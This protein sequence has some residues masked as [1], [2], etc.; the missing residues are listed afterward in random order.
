M[1]ITLNEVRM[2]RNKVLG[3]ILA[4]RFASDISDIP[5]PELFVEFQA[6]GVDP[7]AGFWSYRSFAKWMSDHP[8]L[9]VETVGAAGARKRRVLVLDDKAVAFVEVMTGVRPVPFDFE[10]VGDAIFFSSMNYQEI[11]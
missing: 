7:E 4:R 1:N 8:S 2:I 11:A 10:P 5:L 3:D 9:T 6:A